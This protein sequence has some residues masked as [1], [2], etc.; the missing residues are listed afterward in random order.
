MSA[1]EAIQSNLIDLVPGPASQ[2]NGGISKGDVSA[3]TGGDNIFYSPIKTSDRAGAGILT[4]IVLSGL[5][6]GTW[7]LV[8]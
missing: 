5:I 2:G 4:F 7:W 3:G 8:T 6:G 1:L